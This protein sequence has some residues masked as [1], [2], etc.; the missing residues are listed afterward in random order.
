[1]VGIRILCL[2][3]GYI[4]GLFQT[5][6]ILGKINNFDFR[7]HGSGNAGMTNVMR[8]KGF[9]A[10]L[11]VFFGDS[12]KAV[13]AIVIVWY[14]FKGTYPEYVKLFEFYA[15]LGAVLGNDFPFYLKFRGGK[16]V[17][18]SIG[19]VFSTYV[20]MVPVCTI[21]FFAVT[22]PT[23]FVSLGSLMILTS[24]FVQI[25]IFGQLGYL[26]V[27]DAALP[28]LYLLAAIIAVICFIRHK[29]NIKRLAH[30]TEN[31]FSIHKQEK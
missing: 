9:K 16:G 23:R 3:I 2:V 11:I 19:V 12:L 30:G 20:F 26:G 21:L 22:L 29:E 1:M 24:Y 18:C 25:L 14:A 8:T 7:A 13:L 28:E 10:G 31:R 6:V 15:A 17:A 4:C 5:G 27:A